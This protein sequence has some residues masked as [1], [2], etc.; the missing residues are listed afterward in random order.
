MPGP[1]A[2]SPALLAGGKTSGHPGLQRYGGAIGA[3]RSKDGCS[4]RPGGR[5]RAHHCTAA[6]PARQYPSCGSPLHHQHSTQQSTGH[7]TRRSAQR[8]AH[9]TAQHSAQHPARTYRAGPHDGHPLPRGHARPPAGMDAH[10]TGAG[11]RQASRVSSRGSKAPLTP[12][13]TPPN[14]PRHHRATTTTR[15][16]TRTP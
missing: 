11:R 3:G 6:W 1:P 10:C 9:S 12:C 13:P 15:P 5:L 2:A 8:S 4:S 14:P 16:N 7:S